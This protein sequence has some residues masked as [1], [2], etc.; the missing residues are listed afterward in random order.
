MTKTAEQTDTVPDEDAEVEALV[1]DETP[2]GV[3]Q[4]DHLEY[5]VGLTDDERHGLWGQPLK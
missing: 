4:A 1:A 5:V 3:S 2:L